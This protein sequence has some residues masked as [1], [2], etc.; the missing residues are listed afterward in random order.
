MEAII[1]L[2]I[3]FSCITYIVVSIARAYQRSHR[4]TKMAEITTKL[5][6]RMGSGP[7]LTAFVSSDAYRTLIGT[8]TAP[9]SG[10]VTRIL[11][12]LQ[13]GS[14][15]FAAGAAMLGTANWLPREK[16]RIGVGVIGSVLMSVGAALA[17]SGLWS[18][19]LAKRMMPPQ[20]REDARS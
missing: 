4:D 1:I 6:D 11:N 5:L 18:Q 15:L 10:F 2:P 8:D 17:L 13:A 14:V 9:T 12:S 16:D 19:W 20:D 7:E 3:L